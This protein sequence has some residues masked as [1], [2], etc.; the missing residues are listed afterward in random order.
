MRSNHTPSVY[1]IFYIE[2]D[3]YTTINQDL[4]DKGYDKK[5]KAIVPTIRILRKV[6]H[7]REVYEEIPLLFN[8]GFIRMPKYLA[9]SRDFMNKLQKNIHGIRSWVKSPE[10][11]HA[12]KKKKRIDNTDIWDDFTQVGLATKKEVRRFQRMSRRN[13]RFSVS[14]LV[15]IHP[16]D[17]II[18]KR[19]PY[20]GIEATV[21]SIDKPHKLIRM[22]LDLKLGKMNLDIP[23]DQVLD[24]VYSNYDPELLR[25]TDE[26][27]DVSKITEESISRVLDLRQ[28]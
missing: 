10:Y 27:V 23:F 24:T 22:Q 19:Y 7:G 21:V 18:L 14:D 2:R 3:Y 25:V 15:N 6:I 17:Y 9:Y 8:Y 11:L 13:D 12:K 16:G 20:E 26:E 1:V 5:I 28:F 4:R